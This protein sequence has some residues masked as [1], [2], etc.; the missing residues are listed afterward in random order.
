MADLTSIPPKVIEGPMPA[1]FRASS[2]VR[3]PLLEKA[4]RVSAGIKTS[5]GS[6]ADLG[7]LFAVQHGWR[8]GSAGGLRSRGPY[9]VTAIDIGNAARMTEA[10]HY[11][12]TLA[13]L[14]SAAQSPHVG[15]ITRTL[16]LHAN[17]G[18]LALPVQ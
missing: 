4:E 11:D 9:G 2:K 14:P 1:M 3:M 7:R 8:V 17:I 16:Y 15:H 5:D 12:G 6:V 10:S 18:T 13:P